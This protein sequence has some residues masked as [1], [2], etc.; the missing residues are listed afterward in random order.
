MVDDTNFQKKRAQ[1]YFE[2]LQDETPVDERSE[3]PSEPVAGEVGQDSAAQPAE[4]D[5]LDSLLS[6][7]MVAE[8]SAESPASLEAAQPVEEDDLEAML[9]MPMV[10]EELTASAAEVSAAPLVE[11]EEE[12]F[13]ALLSSSMPALDQAEAPLREV[14]GDPLELD[15]DDALDR[16]IDNLLSEVLPSG[17]AETVLPEARAAD[18][19]LAP[20]L[21]AGDRRATVAAGALPIRVQEH[22]AEAMP[23]GAGTVAEG[24]AVHDGMTLE[25]TLPSAQ[26]SA[27][28]PLPSSA[29]PSSAGLAISADLLVT[30]TDAQRERLDLLQSRYEAEPDDIDVVIR[31][32][33]LMLALGE[34]ALAHSLFLRAQQLDPKNSFVRLKLQT[35]IHDNPDLAPQDT[36]R[37]VLME[38]CGSTIPAAVCA[39]L[40]AMLLTSYVYVAAVLF[41]T[42]VVWL[43]YWQGTTLDRHPVRS[44]ARGGAAMFICFAVP[45]LLALSFQA[46]SPA[47]YSVRGTALT[48]RVGHYARFLAVTE[49]LSE[50]DALQRATTVLD[51]ADPL[52]TSSSG[53]IDLLLLMSLFAMVGGLA[54]YPAALASTY[55][56]GH[57]LTA[58]HVVSSLRL[59][60]AHPGYLKVALS[61]VVLGAV[62][63]VCAVVLTGPVA[64]QLLLPQAVASAGTAGLAGL[65]LGA[66][67]YLVKRQARRLATSRKG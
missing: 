57:A 7:P 22:Q 9:S 63:V 67:L 40:G 38:L 65:I 4:E 60:R 13:E 30:A 8:S 43:V 50:A 2:F 34:A 33:N 54:Y 47:S 16:A 12:D 53:Q 35:V 46:A 42:A 28:P 23:I 1:S 21:G 37:S 44:L 48:E 39:A 51:Q 49:S 18:V 36:T 41:V 24:L 32:A 58:W 11:Q 56:S 3:E 31:L 52:Q 17:S 66:L 15:D 55:V 19:D 64:S 27:A 59:A 20:S 29:S 25:T 10:A 61:T 45:A 62:S 14:A 5:D 6:M 26:P